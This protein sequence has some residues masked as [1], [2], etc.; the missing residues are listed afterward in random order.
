MKITESQ[1]RSIIK[2]ETDKADK[3]KALKKQKKHLQSM[4]KQSADKKGTGA[5]EERQTW[6]KELAKVDS[7][8]KKLTESAS[9]DV[10]KQV[11]DLLKQ[12]AGL[13]K[14]TGWPLSGFIDE[15]NQ[16][17]HEVDGKGY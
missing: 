16:A 8:L 12:A 6:R 13:A 11:A 15:V 5:P 17:W 10:Y 3:V 4:I 9:A 14:S 7:K 2:E 1:L